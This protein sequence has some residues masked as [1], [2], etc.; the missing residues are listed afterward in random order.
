MLVH[1]G[2]NLLQVLF[3][4]GLAPLFEGVL[5]RLKEI[6]QC[7]AGPSIFQ[8]YRD[9]AKLF[10]KDE[11]VST[12]SSWLF[13]LAPYVA[14][15]TPV[16]VA[17]LIP[18]LTSYPLFFA[19][20]GDMLGVGFIL[21]LGGFFTALAAVDTANPYGAMG[22]SRTRMVGFLTE[23]VF[24]I[25]FMTISLVAGSTIPYIV[26][27]DWITPPAAF[28]QPWHLL[29][30]LAF[31]LLILAED[32]RIPVDSPT[33]TFELAM[34]EKSKSLEY[35]GLGAALMKWAGAMKLLV[36]MIVFLN[37]LVAPWGLAGGTSFID[38]LIAV[39]LVAFKVFLFLL[40]LVAIE[41][42]L[43][44]LRLF[45]ITE[46]TSSAFVIAVVAMISR[47]FAS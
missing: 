22:A 4:V 27:K 33:G 16:F 23:P 9:L 15:V 24:L 37:V 42:S 11:V 7:K 10:A 18:V 19:F 39:P 26:Q 32:G 38:V 31:L 29:L 36:L 21:A 47:L 20:M 35:S 14:F 13:R 25:V 44:K 41:S 5:T 8:P 43:S 2:Y 3:V 46:F 12:Q 40:L 30:V 6:V 1:L 34:I 28:F 17:L 45:R